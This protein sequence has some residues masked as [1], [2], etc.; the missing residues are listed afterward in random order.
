MTPAQAIAWVLDHMD[1]RSVD[2]AD[3]LLQLVGKEITEALFHASSQFTPAAKYDG[4]TVILR[5]EGLRP[6]S[7]SRAPTTRLP[8]LSDVEWAA[9]PEPVQRYIG[10][11]ETNADPA[12]MVLE[13][14]QLSDQLQA[15]AARIAE[16]NETIERIRAEVAA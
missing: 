5:I 11:M 1:G 3:K 15:M 10:A 14:A 7:D 2:T 9:L 16:Q 13:N 12:L 8:Y 6:E 4:Q